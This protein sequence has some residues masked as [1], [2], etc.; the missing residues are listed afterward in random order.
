VVDNPH[1]TAQSAGN[2]GPAHY[3]LTVER[4]IENDYPVPSYLADVFEK[5]DGWIETPQAGTNVDSGAQ[6]LGLRD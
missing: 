3:L 5:P 2:K 6:T 1:S 4:M